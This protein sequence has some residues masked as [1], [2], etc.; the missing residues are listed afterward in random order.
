[1]HGSILLLVDKL[2]ACHADNFIN[3]TDDPETEHLVHA[4]IFISDPVDC[5]VPPDNDLSEGVACNINK[6]RSVEVDT[7]NRS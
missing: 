7:G 3:A 6:S 4:N 1:M 5:F 2:P